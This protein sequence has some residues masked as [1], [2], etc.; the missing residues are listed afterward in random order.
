MEA[1]FEYENVVFNGEQEK[2]SI[3]HVRM[4]KKNLSLS[5]ATC[6]HSASFVMP[7]G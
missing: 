3:I 4:G 6:H 1:F 5:I 7:N 2:E